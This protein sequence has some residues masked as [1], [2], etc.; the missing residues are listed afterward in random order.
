MDSSSRVLIVGGGVA[1]LSLAQG[2]R[3]AKIPFHVFE[4]DSNSDYRAQ[5]YQ[6]RISSEGASALR[7][8][9]SCELWDRFEDS[10]AEYVEGGTEFDAISGQVTGRRTG[11]P[12][13]KRASHT[14]WIGRS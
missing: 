11:L 13:G 5:G 1:G 6:I 8:N 2:L 14:P 9:L 3:K 10:C 4:K 7:Q 12:H